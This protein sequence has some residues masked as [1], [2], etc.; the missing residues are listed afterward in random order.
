MQFFGDK[1][2]DLVRVVQIGGAPNELNGYSMELCGGTHVRATGEIGLFRILS[3][4][5]IAAGI[6]R[7]EAVAGAALESWAT[8]EAA[9][10]DEK[11]A[12]PNEKKTR[13][14]AA[15]RILPAT[16]RSTPARRTS[17]RSRP[18]C[19]SGRKE[20]PRPRARN[21]RNAPLRSRRN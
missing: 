11:F 1:Y 14:P 21:C 19:A 6:R 12:W 20:T 7:I 13:P 2:G 9:Q 3:E 16:P 8:A 18:S 15:P 4:A 10:Q 5:A 17:R